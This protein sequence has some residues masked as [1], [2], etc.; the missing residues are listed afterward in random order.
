MKLLIKYVL[1]T[2]LLLSA[3]ISAPA[4]NKPDQFAQ[5]REIISKAAAS[6]Q[7]SVKLPPGTYRG[8]ADPAFP[9]AHL[10]LKDLNDMVIDGSG[11][12]LICQD[13]LKPATA[14]KL[15]NCR[16]VE[17]KGFTIDADPLCF[18][19]GKIINMAPDNSYF[20]LKI[21][22][23]YQDIDFFAK[24][25]KVTR[26]MN[27][28]DPK[29]RTWKNGVGDIYFSKL[30]KLKPGLWRIHARNKPRPGSVAKGDQAVICGRGGCAVSATN[31]EDLTYRD[32]TIYQSGVLA[33]HEHGGGGNTKIIGCTVTRRPGTDRLISSVADGFHC[34]NM[35]KGPTVI[36]STFQ[37]MMD[38]GTNIHTMFGRV[39]EG[40][41]AVWKLL[42]RFENTI[43]PGD[44]LEFYPA[45][46]LKPLFRATVKSC[47][48]I[49][50]LKPEERKRYW[51]K[52]GSN[53]S[54][55]LVTFDR[56]LKLNVR[57]RYINLNAC[58]A[59]FT[60]RNCIYGPLRY[61][62]I[63]LRSFDGVIE[64]CKFQYTGNS[65]IS[66]ESDFN[67]SGEGPYVDNL[68]IRNNR[69][70]NIGSFPGWEKGCGIVICNFNWPSPQGPELEKIH[71][72]ITITGN[73][74]ADTANDAIHVEHLKNG[75][76]KDN[77]FTRIG[78]RNTVKS[79]SPIPVN[80]KNSTNVTQKNNKI[81]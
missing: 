2:T 22:P 58:G 29:T 11:I 26:P 3:A 1:P 6:G 62:G 73:S 77:I 16:N 66:I 81:K 40:N 4:E 37:Y 13:F 59:G 30:E 49:K 75:I 64:N 53:G 12:E 80:I 48:P 39:A 52:F 51:G 21:D 63:L 18:T 25:R 67:C 50:P 35:R 43:R 31:C 33:F 20:D 68:T 27:I 10:L 24:F 7:K 34:K 44:T 23:G 38:D 46:K 42:P 78:S 60:I 54:V 36:D 61:R 65:A 14:I 32:L 19:Q 76:I 71:R 47:Q 5:L 41:G 45:N 9:G 79:S 74:F 69:F 70:E 28:F 15:I 55:R 57:D 72:N 56:P 17:I 8:K